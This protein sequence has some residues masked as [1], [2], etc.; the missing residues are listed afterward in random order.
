VVNVVV[1]W[2]LCWYRYEVDLSDDGP[3]VRLSAQGYELDELAPGELEI[4][5]AAHERG[6]LV[7]Q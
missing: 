3:N 7:L 6:T 4:N 2:E 1:S 5:A